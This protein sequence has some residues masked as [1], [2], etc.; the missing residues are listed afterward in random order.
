MRESVRTDVVDVAVV[1]AGIVSLATAYALANSRPDL[2]IA[3]L[4]KEQRI[5]THQTGRNSG[6]IHAGLYYAPGSLKAQLSVEG[7]RRLVEFCDEH[8]IAT[9]RTGKVVLATNPEQVPA[10]DEL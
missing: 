6:V 5:A 4:E 7:G 9:T 10:L 2:A 1:G 8:G 3:V